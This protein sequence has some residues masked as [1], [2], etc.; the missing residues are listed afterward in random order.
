VLPPTNELDELMGQLGG[1]S[2]APHSSFGGYGGLP[3]SGFAS[4]PSELEVLMSDLSAGPPAAGVPT[5]TGELEALMANLE[6]TTGMG[7]AYGAGS[8][9]GAQVGYPG[10]MKQGGFKSG[11]SQ[12]GAGFHGREVVES[13][14]D[15]L[16]ALMYDLGSPAQAQ[17][18]GGPSRPP[19]QRQPS[20]QTLSPVSQPDELEA[21]LSTLG[22]GT[23][24]PVTSPY[25][26]SGVRPNNLRSTSQPAN[27]YSSPFTNEPGSRSSI[28]PSLH[29]IPAGARASVSSI[30][31][32]A[33][34]EAIMDKL[35]TPSSFDM[36]STQ[37]QVGTPQRRQE[38]KPPKGVCAGCRKW[39]A[40]SS[41]IQAMGKEYH[42]EHFQ[43]STCN[44]VIG[45]SNFFEREGQPQCESCY[46]SVFC[47]KCANCGIPIKSQLVTA[48]GQSWHPNCFV[49]SSCRAPFPTG[50]FYERQGRPFCA[51]C[52]NGA[53]FTQM[54][55]MWTTCT[56]KCHKCV[57]VIM[58]HGVL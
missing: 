17:R 26:V 37:A 34:L 18:A 35:D 24:T 58:A 9:Y 51:S 44:C 19:P 42:P 2:P 52:I 27:Q 30:R 39:I 22:S 53:F 54:S 6:D 11:M 16:E 21:M 1:V 23:P 33:D 4:E 55:W 43:C 28:S 14:A 56:W 8:G 12:M 50:A 31:T 3:P 32:T 7:G 20:G 40:G 41:K 38:P 49:C 48:L 15:E 5:T 29:N 57:R 13:G 47:S 25:G 46:E 10:T 45:G 36:V